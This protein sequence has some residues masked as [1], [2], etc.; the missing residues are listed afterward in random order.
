MKVT[1]KN[2]SAS[3]ARAVNDC[4]IFYFCGPDESGASDAAAKIAG[5]LGEAEKVDLS[6]AELKRDPVRLADEARSVSLFGDRRIIHVRAT[7]DD[8]HDAVE[9]LLQSPVDGWP[10]LIV[11]SSATDKSRIAKL[12]ENR[13]DALV[14]MFHPPDLK[15]VASAIR[16][17]ADAMGV[18]M[19]DE[20]S[21]RVAR[22]TALDT[23]MARSELEKIALYLDASPQAPRT[24]TAADLDEV[25][26]VSEDDGMMPLVNAVLGG[27][28]RRIPAELS[29]MREQGMNPVG[30]VLALE[31]RAGQLVQLAGRLGE[32]GDVNAFMQQESDARRVF[33]RD[34]ADLTQQLKRWRG[35]R[36]VRLCQ[37]LVQLHRVLIADNR[38]GEL[39][40]AQGLAEIARAAAR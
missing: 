2:F 40:L 36:L 27:E 28:V 15:S 14:G 17:S 30:L 8:A 11:A 22:A 32:R 19:T 10:V 1:Q 24:A 34:R 38:N 21:E 29:R 6:G 12:L 16:S 7:G 18:R 35:P 39:A 20:L 37:R 33:F 26:A 3:A 9:T 23:R 25:C 13:A 4:R 31:R 5:M